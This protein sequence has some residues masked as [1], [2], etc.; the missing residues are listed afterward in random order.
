MYKLGPDVPKDLPFKLNKHNGEIEISRKLDYE[1]KQSYTFDVISEDGGKPPKTDKTSVTIEIGNINDNPP[2]F[3]K[4]EY[5]KSIPEDQPK[6]VP[7]IT[8]TAE[9]PDNLMTE[10]EYE[11]SIAE[12]NSENCFQIDQYMGIVT[13]IGCNLDFKTQKEYR[14]KLKVLDADGLAGY[15]WLTLKIYDANNNAPK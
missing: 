15:A 7:I 3:M 6:G 8:V 4:N 1:M 9:D 5:F 12:G 2:R 10:D 14:L 11:F 13:L